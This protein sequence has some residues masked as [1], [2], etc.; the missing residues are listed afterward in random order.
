[1]ENNLSG[2][3]INIMSQMLTELN[4]VLKQAYLFLS[5]KNV[6]T[7]TRNDSTHTLAQLCPNVFTKYQTFDIFGA[8]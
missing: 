1:M 4:L 7:F 5:E 3:L 8:L 2:S 6:Y